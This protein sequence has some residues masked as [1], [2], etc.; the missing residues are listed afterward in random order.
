MISSLSNSNWQVRLDQSVQLVL[1]LSSAVERAEPRVT[2]VVFIVELLLQLHRQS[3]LRRQLRFDGGGGG[4]L[5]VRLGRHQR[6]QVRRDPGRCGACGA[7]AEI[8]VM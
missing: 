4:G 7:G 3:S 1:I 2:V 8:T 6:V 5:A